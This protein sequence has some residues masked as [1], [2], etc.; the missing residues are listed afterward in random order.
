MNEALKHIEDAQDSLHMA[1]ASIRPSQ[2]KSSDDYVSW[3]SD[4]LSQAMELASLKPILV[5]T[6]DG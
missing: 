1:W 3:T 2:F 4:V 6:L 5:E